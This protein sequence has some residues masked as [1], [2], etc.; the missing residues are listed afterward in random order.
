[1][2]TS[3]ADLGRFGLLDRSPLEGSAL[4]RS[5][6]VQPNLRELVEGSIGS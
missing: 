5:P 1:M 3:R 4:Q 6:G 2:F